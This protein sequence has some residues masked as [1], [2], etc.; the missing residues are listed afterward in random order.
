MGVSRSAEPQRGRLIVIDLNDRTAIVTGAGGGIG[1]AIAAKMCAL[2]ARVGVVDVDEKQAA[3]EVKRLEQRGHAAI[4]IAG[5]VREE[6]VMQRAVD[7]VADRWGRVDILVNNAGI[8]RDN[9]IENISEEDWD[10]VID[11]NLKGAFFGCRAAVPRMKEQRHGKIINIISRAWLGNVGQSNYSASKGG[12]VSLTRTLALELAPHGINV[13]GVAPGLI[14]TPMTQKLPQ[15]VRDRLIQMQPTKQMGTVDDVAA[16]VCFL[17][18]D[19]SRF[20]TG[21]ILHV[22]GG[23]SCGLAAGI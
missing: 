17:A 19:A 4:V 12:L 21:Q 9:F 13:N 10:A 20:I 1:V 23:K 3:A 22:D 6:R 16:A 5:D 18:S 14:D 2:G 8:I 7:E 11:V 15:K